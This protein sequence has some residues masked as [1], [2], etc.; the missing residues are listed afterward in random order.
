V[1]QNQKLYEHQG[2]IATIE[3]GARQ[4][5]AA[6]GRFLSV[7]PVEG[8]VTNADDY[9]ADPINRTDLSGTRLDAPP[10]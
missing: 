10:G 6:L 7:D 2:T 8:G 3:M 5:A 1:G 9:P 4:F